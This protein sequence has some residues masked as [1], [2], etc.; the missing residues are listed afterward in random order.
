VVKYKDGYVVRRSVYAGGSSAKNP[1]RDCGVFY[2]YLGFE[3]AVKKASADAKKEIKDYNKSMLISK[4][5]ALRKYIALRS[6][7]ITG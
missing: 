2:N 1:T 7:P 4:D 6:P 3:E 5:E